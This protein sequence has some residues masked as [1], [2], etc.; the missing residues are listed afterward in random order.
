MLSP[1]L[2]DYLE[3]LY[4]FS[5]FNN[6]VRVT[7]ISNKLDVTL[8]SVNKAFHKLRSEE[9]ITYERY[10]DITLTEKGKELGDFL[11]RR[12]QL[13][14]EF[15]M[16]IRCKC[17]IAAEAEAMEHY[18]SIE[19]IRSIQRVVTY[20]KGNPEWYQSFVECINS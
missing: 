13:L 7:D 17:D 14:Q 6:T 3:E 19:T 1:S 15:L 11:V 20:M 18:L 2:E 12:N 9:Y 8:P 5:L 16:L 4:R 10:G